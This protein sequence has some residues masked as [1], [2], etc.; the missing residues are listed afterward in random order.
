M[1]QNMVANSSDFN[2][3]LV[4][5]RRFVF[6]FECS[7]HFEKNADTFA[8]LCESE[9]TFFR[10]DSRMDIFSHGFANGDRV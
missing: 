8:I 4:S 5:E 9:W 2:I 3:L 10:M 7:R 1:A 6:F